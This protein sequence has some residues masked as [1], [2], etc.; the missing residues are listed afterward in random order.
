VTA[1][2]VGR[3]SDFPPGTHAVVRIGRR[4]IGIFNIDG[5]LFGLPNV[6]PH[7]TGPLCTAPR[8]TG[9]L[10]SSGETGWI[11]RW[12]HDGEVV[13]CPWHGLE[14][15]VPTGQCLAFAGIRLRTYPVTVEGDDVQVQLS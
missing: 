8:T 9:T 4:E 1:Q 13:V 6:C 5:R 10:E 12:V 7:Q 14:F 11:P 3:V 15:H 2:V